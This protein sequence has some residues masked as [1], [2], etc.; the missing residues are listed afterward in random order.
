VLATALV[1]GLL[2]GAG[3]AGAGLRRLPDPPGLDPAGLAAAQDR[4]VE[5]LAAFGVPLFCGGGRIPDIALTFDD[6]PSPYTVPLLRLL[7]RSHASATFFLVGNRLADWPDAAPDEASL[8]ALGDHTWSHARLRGLRYRT[9]A[10]EIT[11]GRRAVEAADRRKVLLFRPPYGLMTPRLHRLVTRLG[12]LDV[13]WSIDSGDSRPGATVKS[14]VRTVE[15]GARPG[16]IVLLHDI[17]PWTVV[18]VR[19]LLPWFHHHALWPV[20]VPELLRIDPPTSRQ[21]RGDGA[22]RCPP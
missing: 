21:L 8:G 20:S 15:A 2:T 10:W 7:R 1:A 5:R 14:V 19:R 11:A 13:R 4:V 12:M 3:G 18:A 16:S 22:Q 17:H 9:A 6:G